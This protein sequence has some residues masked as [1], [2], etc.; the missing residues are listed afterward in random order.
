M[1]V[2]A[3]YNATPGTQYVMEQIGICSSNIRT[4][5]LGRVGLSG[6]RHTTCSCLLA[7]PAGSDAPAPVMLG[8]GRSST[9][10]LLHITGIS[11]RANRVE[12]I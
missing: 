3:G 6:E 7:L 11:P 10:S 2:M 12:S 1:Y 8:T 4:H 5:P 9:Q